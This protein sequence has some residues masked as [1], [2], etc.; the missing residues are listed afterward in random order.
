MRVAT[1]VQLLSSLPCG[2]CYSTNVDLD[3]FSGVATTVTSSERRASYA[4]P[5]ERQPGSVKAH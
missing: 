1:R 4:T 2:G 3:P 5:T